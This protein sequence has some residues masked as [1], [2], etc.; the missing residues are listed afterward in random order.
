[1]TAHISMKG[2]EEASRECPNCHSRKNWKDGFRDTS[3][4]SVQRLI[5]RDC[6][7]RFSDKSYK[8][9]LLNENRQLC[10]QLEA[11]KLDAATETKT[12]AGEYSTQLKV[13]SKILEHAWWLQKNGRSETTIESRVKL[14]KTLVKR[15][16]NLN[17][18]E[19][20]KDVIA[21]QTWCAGRKNNAS[22]AYSAYLKMVG[23]KWEKPQYKTVR[24][25]PFIP[26]ETEIDQLIAG[27]SKRMATFLQML[28][29]TGARCGEIWWLK[30]EDIDFESKV[31][32]ITPEKN[33]NPRTIRLSLKLL[34]MLQR[35]P[36][37]YGNRVFSFSDMRV[38]HHGLSLSR[39]RKRIAN[40]LNN[41]RLLKIHFHTFRYWRGTTL[42]HKTKDPYFV[43]QQLGH[44]SIK[45]TEL[46]VQLDHAYFEGEDEYISKVAKTQK[47]ILFLIDQG[48]EYVTEFEGVKFFRKR[49]L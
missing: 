28:K 30:W 27:C 18:P 44:K 6:G 15:G 36:K 49:K 25:L 26:K 35:L 10:A 29:E 20:V 7:Y 39:Q 33:S 43:Q 19:T 40:K 38:D 31:V 9:S 14:L 2:G 8:D 22:D 4:R 24:K 3:C 16:A 32:S 1:M 47:E 5:C 23:G 48:F 11:K 12:V 17:D 13:D 34:E 21:K 46:Y 41:P 45:N 37:A 42:Y